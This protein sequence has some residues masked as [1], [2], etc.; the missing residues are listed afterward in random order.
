MNTGPSLNDQSEGFCGAQERLTQNGR[1]TFPIERKMKLQ[2]GPDIDQEK[3]S[4]RP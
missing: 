4:E 1:K 2:T 3:M